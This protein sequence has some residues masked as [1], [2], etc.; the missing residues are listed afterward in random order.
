M[1]ENTYIGSRD[2]EEGR[3]KALQYGLEGWTGEIKRESIK[4]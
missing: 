1:K 3:A 2:I 4:P